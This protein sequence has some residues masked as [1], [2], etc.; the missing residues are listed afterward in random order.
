MEMILPVIYAI[1]GISANV[2]S[3]IHCAQTGQTLTP[4][5]PLLGLA[6]MALYAGFV[7][8]RF[9]RVPSGTGGLALTLCAIAYGGIYRH[10]RTP[11]AMGYAST[12]SRYAAITI[13][14]FGVVAT[15]PVFF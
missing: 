2:C 4:V 9:H 6:T 10:W 13:N 8:L 14:L 12:R 15:V 5:R 3:Q 7:S 11:T 1:L